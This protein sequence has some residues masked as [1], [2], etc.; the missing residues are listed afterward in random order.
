MDDTAVILAVVEP[1]ASVSDGRPTR[2]RS[3]SITSVSDGRP[4]STAGTPHQGVVPTL[5]PG[6]PIASV[7][8]GR[9][10]HALNH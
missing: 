9:P 1:I 2:A 7:P 5:A 6:E 4:P 8:D 3:E 10:D